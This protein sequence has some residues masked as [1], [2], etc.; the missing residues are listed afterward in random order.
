MPNRKYD[1]GGY[2]FSKILLSTVIIASLSTFAYADQTH[3]H[4][5]PQH[6]N[7]LLI[8]FISNHSKKADLTKEVEK[9]GNPMA[10]EYT[11]ASING[12]NKSEDVYNDW[13]QR[14]NEKNKEAYV[15]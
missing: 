6:S 15:R 2:M 9:S 4:P 12:T 13:T 5:E 8:N 14:F 7:L 10:V 11:K 3:K 1:P